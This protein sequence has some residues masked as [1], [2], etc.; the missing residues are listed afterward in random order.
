MY[1]MESLIF[2]TPKTSEISVYYFLGIL[3]SKLINYLFATKFLNLAVKGDYLKKIKF[4]ISNNTTNLDSIS[5]KMIH[6]NKEITQN[7]NKFSSYLKSNFQI[8]KLSNKLQN[9][10]E[11][12]FA[13]F[14]KELNKTIKKASGEKLT[15]KD[16]MEWM[17]LFD[18][19]KSQAN[20]FKEQID[21]TDKEID[22]MVYQLYGLTE[23][24]IQIVENSI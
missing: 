18:D 1:G 4:P 9:W 19:Y 20:Y 14:I 17:E 24:E 15:K 2:L 10:H 11:L 12:E 21:K 7:I 3:N 8:K 13:D 16:E 23:E 22:Q 6:L 5:K